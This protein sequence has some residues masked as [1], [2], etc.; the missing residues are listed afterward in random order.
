MGGIES[1]FFC[2]CCTQRIHKDSNPPLINPYPK[3]YRPYTRCLACGPDAQGPKIETGANI[4]VGITPILGVGSEILGYFELLTEECRNFG[5]AYLVITL[6]DGRFLKLEQDGDGKPKGLD[7]DTLCFMKPTIIP[8]IPTG[9]LKVGHFAPLSI[10]NIVDGWTWLQRFANKYYTRHPHFYPIKRNCRTFAD[11]ILRVI[12]SDALW[13]QAIE[14]DLVKYKV[15]IDFGKKD[16]RHIFSPIEYLTQCCGLRPDAFTAAI[17]KTIPS[18]GL[19]PCTSTYNGYT[20]SV[21][22]VC[23][24]SNTSLSWHNEDSYTSDSR[25]CVAANR[26]GIPIGEAFEVVSG[27]GIAP[28]KQ[29][30][31]PDTIYALPSPTFNIQKNRRRSRE[32]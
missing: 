23:A 8:A 21:V 24:G 25:H 15:V 32:D 20:G 3:D 9:A 31:N 12:V 27:Y 28:F 30:N 13:K 16:I 17:T 26:C 14:A 7:I 5:H 6:T 1:R 4:F 2:D 19:F 10:P 29:V 11:E 22:C 18:V